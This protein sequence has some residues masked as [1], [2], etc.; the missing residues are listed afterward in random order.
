VKTKKNK[1][2]NGKKNLLKYEILSDGTVVKTISGTAANIAYEFAR[3]AI[4]NGCHVEYY[5]ADFLSK[6]YVT[7]CSNIV[8]LRLVQS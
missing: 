5:D 1:K 7:P 2:K 3:Y 6:V 4:D 8:S